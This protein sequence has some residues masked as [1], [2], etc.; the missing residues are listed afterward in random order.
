MAKWD[1]TKLSCDNEK[2]EP[3]KLTEEELRWMQFALKGLMHSNTRPE[4]VRLQR[5]LNRWAD[6]P[7]LI[8]NN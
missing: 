8:F 3:M 5:K 2:V 1:L 4:L 7:D 6:H